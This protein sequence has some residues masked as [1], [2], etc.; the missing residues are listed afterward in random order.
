MTIESRIAALRQA[1]QARKVASK[2]S[3]SLV[4]FVSSLSPTYSVTPGGSAITARIK[5]QADSPDENGRSMV[6]LN[7][8]VSS[9]SS[10]SSDYIWRFS[11]N[12]PQAGDGS[13][14]IRLTIAVP[15][16]DTATY[17]FR[18]RSAGSTTGTFTRLS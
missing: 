10:F 11:Y 16:D 7:A 2:I 12:E 18:I 9:N 17:Y 4:R 6:N 3:A 15:E 5:F 8:E 1:N 13:I 14:V